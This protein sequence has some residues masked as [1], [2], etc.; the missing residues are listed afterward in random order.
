MQTNVKVQDRAIR[1]LNHSSTITLKI[2]KKQI[3]HASRKLAILLLFVTLWALLFTTYNTNSYQFWTLL[4]VT[5]I[6]GLV[7]F[8]ANKSNTNLKKPN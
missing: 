6:L 8:V 4:K 1:V 3:V 7:A 2:D 5:V